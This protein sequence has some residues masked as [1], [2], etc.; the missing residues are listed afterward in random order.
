MQQT[1][2]NHVLFP[3]LADPDG[4]VA[5]DWDLTEHRDRFR[6]WL[7][8]FRGH[9]PTM[10]EEAVHEAVD[11]GEPVANVRQ[12]A[13]GALRHFHAFLDDLKQRFDSLDSL[14]IISIC[15]AR[16]SALRAFDIDDAYRHIKRKENDATLGLLPTL[17]EHLD[18]LPVRD[19]ALELLEGIFAG[20]IFDLGA[21]ETQS[22][23]L[24]EG[25]MLSVDIFE[26]TR[27][28]VRDKPRPW[29]IDDLDAWLV[30][31]VD[32]PAYRRAVLFVDNA[33]SDIVLGMVPFARSLINAGTHVILTA[34]SGP[35]LND[36]TAD[37]LVELLDR[38]AQ[39]DEPVR[40]A[41]HA[42][43]LQ[44]VPSGNRLPLIDLSGVST[45]LVDAVTRDGGVDLV[46]LEGMGRAIES[47]LHALFTCD[48]LKLAMIKDRDVAHAI[49][50]EL[51]D[52]M[53]KYEPVARAGI[54]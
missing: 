20:N 18:A 3:L 8:I 53:L 33:G 27:A 24:D 54:Q 12:R 23:F 52:V 22:M 17:L 10:L 34:N 48:A 42:G 6:H 13:D 44:V 47:N 51:Y 21:T 31:I 30:R 2:T 15:K 29:P 41:L 26:K 39:I 1:I 14:A 4:Y 7:G 35:S 37:E 11:R 46:V 40:D 36:V 9:F 28:G 5:C 25:G 38:V 49:G 43:Q 50:G 32:G 16:E 45:Q 19:R